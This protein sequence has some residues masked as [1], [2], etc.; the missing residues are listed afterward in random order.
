MPS[1]LTYPGVYIEEIPSGVRTITGVAT[2]ITAFVGYTARG[3]VDTAVRIQSFADFERT[4]GG[5]NRDSEISYAVQQFFLNGGTDAYVV[6][7]ALNALAPKVT[8]RD[9]ALVSVLDVT[10]ATPGTWGNNVRLDVDYATANPDSSFNL[11]VVRYDLQN[12]NLVPVENESYANLSMNNRSSNYALNVVNNGSKLIRLALSGGLTF[13]NS[14]YSLSGNLSTVPTMTANDNTLAG[15][16]DS[17]DPFTLTLSNPT[18]INAAVD[19]IAEVVNQISAAITAAGLNAR[20]TVSRTDPKGSASGTGTFLKLTS[21]DTDQNSSV[22]MN[23]ASANDAAVKLKLGLTNGGREAE[24]ASSHRPAQTGLTSGDLTTVLGT[25]VALAATPITVTFTDN[26]SASVI[27]PTG[28]IT[29]PANVAVDVTLAA[30]L[31]QK[32]R[33]IPNPAAQQATVKLAGAY[34]RIVPSAATPN[35][36]ISFSGA[37]ADTLL[38]TV[39]NG[40]SINVQK[41][42]LGGGA[43][44][45]AQTGAAMGA[46]G[47]PPTGAQFLGDGDHTGI[48]ALRKVDLFN[49]IVIPRT[50]QLTG[51]EPQ[52][53]LAA[54]IA[55]CEE[56]RAFFIVDPDPNKD[57]T[58]V[59]SWASQIST[60]RNAAVFFPRVKVADPL[61]NFRLRDMP[62]SGALAGVFSRTDAARGVWKAPAGTDATLAGV[63]GLSYTLTDAENGTL[64]PLGINC[65]RT[66]PVYGTIVWGSRTMRGADQQADEYK[67]IPVRRVALFLEESLYRGL[68]WVVFEPNDEPLWAQ[69]RLNVGAFM[70]NLF[71]QGAF[72]GTTPQQAYFVKCDKTTTTQNDIDNGIVNIV[73]GFA[74]LKPAEFVVIKIQ[75]IAGQIQT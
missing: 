17:K 75:Q 73:V 41:Y 15:I 46:D 34:L 64:N 65:L 3:P 70:H 58:T 28:T 36:S 54:A 42:S 67:Y 27:P 1:T 20:L 56:R 63:Q 38:L 12:G 24:G 31:Q 25:N 60:S 74:P 52:S 39:V 66:F 47:T 57:L 71:R 23:L 51:N 50:T 8:L 11:T 33:A 6:R 68:K 7:V 62:P 61:D 59:A 40:A 43:S 55:L 22:Q 37:D 48:Y 45:G 2:S 9:V 14:S 19:K 26:T 53:V 32:L 35:A 49:L 21:S 30:T 29:L 13:S 16:L 44:F 72:Q 69:I 4:F 18:A 10:A 5:L